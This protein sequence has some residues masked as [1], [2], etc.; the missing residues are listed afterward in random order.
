MVMKEKISALMDDE[1]DT[2]ASEHLFAALKKDGNVLECWSTYHRIGDAMRGASELSDDFYA[3][4]MQRVDAEPAVLAPKRRIS[5][6]QHPL[7]SVAASVAAVL[8]VGW[9]LMQQQEAAI[10]DAP[11]MASVAQNTVTPESVN[12]YLVAHRQLS[13]DSITQAAYYLR[14]VDYSENGN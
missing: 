12:A 1:L 14:P 7:M 13:P 6:K 5:I 3:R 4:L 8:V 2:G 11:A 10:T 9:V